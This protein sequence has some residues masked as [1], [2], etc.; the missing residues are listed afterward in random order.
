MRK[1]LT[2]LILLCF[3]AP[4]YGRST[5]ANPDFSFPEDV[6]SVAD[7]VLASRKA[8]D[9]DR[10]NA[11][12]QYAS[13][14]LSRDR[15]SLA[16]VVRR[17]DTE[18]KR[19]TQPDARALMLMYKATLLRFAYNVYD[20]KIYSTVAPLDSLPESFEL[21]SELQ[22]NQQIKLLVDQAIEVMQPVQRS[23]LTRYD[24]ILRW[25][26]LYGERNDNQLKYAPYLR[27][28]I[29]KYAIACVIDG[30]AQDYVAEMCRRADVGT[31]EWVE[32]NSLLT[33]YAPLQLYRQW[34]K[35]DAGAALLLDAEDSLD[36]YRFNNTEQRRL[37]LI[38]YIDDLLAKGGLSPDFVTDL[39]VALRK[40]KCPTVQLNLSGDAFACGTNLQL[41]IKSRF[42]HK[43]GIAVYEKSNPDADIRINT[44]TP[45][46]VKELET[47]YTGETQRDT[48]DIQFDQPGYYT[49][50]LMCNGEFQGLNSRDIS[51]VPYIPIVLRTEDRY[52]AILFDAATG[53]CA[54]D[55]EL[56]YLMGDY[57]SLG[58]TN[59]DGIV[60]WTKEAFYLASGIRL[61]TQDSRGRFIYPRGYCYQSTPASR[62]YQVRFFTPRKV[63][64]RGDTLQWS[65]LAYQPQDRSVEAHRNINVQFRDAN[66]VVFE[67]IAVTTDEYGRATGS[68][69]LPDDRLA[70][71]YYITL[72]GRSYSD[73][74]A[75]EVSDFKIP[76]F[77]IVDLDANRAADGHYVVTGRC[78]TFSGAAVAF[79]RITV[80]EIL[81]YWYRNSRESDIFAT[82][83]TAEDG[84]FSVDLPAEAFKNSQVSL[85]FVANSPANDAA[86]AKLSLNISYPVHINYNSDI[87]LQYYFDF[88]RDEPFQLNG[89]VC[90][91][92]DKPIEQ[93]MVWRMVD[94]DST[95]V[96]NGSFKSNLQGLTTLDFSKIPTGEYE[97]FVATADSTLAKP[98][99][100]TVML[101]SI[102]DN[103]VPRPHGYVAPQTDIQSDA[104][105]H[106]QLVIGTCSEHAAVLMASADN[107]TDFFIC[108]PIRLKA[109]ITRIDVQ[110]PDGAKRAECSV[111]FVDGLDSYVAEYT[112]TRPDEAQFTFDIE[113]WRDN[114]SAGEPCQWRI[115]LRR[116]DGAPA[117]AAMVAT[118]YNRALDLLGGGQPQFL[119][120]YA[121]DYKKDLLRNTTF[122]RSNSI[123]LYITENYPRDNYSYSHNINW[124]NYLYGYDISFEVYQYGVAYGV[125]RRSDV[126]VG[127]PVRSLN[128]CMLREDVASA[129]AV[130]E[131]SAVEQKVTGNSL[132][133]EPEAL[134]EP[135]GDVT[136]RKGDVLQALW[137]PD[138]TTNADGSVTIDFNLPNANGRWAFVL[139]A[140]TTDLHT[141]GLR[142][143]VTTSKPLMVQP[144][145]PRFLRHGDH[146]TLSATVYN[147]SDQRLDATAIIEVYNPANDSIIA[148]S[149][150]VLNLAANGSALTSID[151]VMITDLR[152]I[153]VR[154]KA[155]T[156]HFS[157]GEVN[158]LPV[159]EA[160]STVIESNTFYLNA[161]RPTFEMQLPENLGD[162]TTL[163]YCQNPI[164]EVVKALPR[165][166][167]DELRT[168]TGTAA[169]LFGAVVAQGIAQQHPEV[170]EGIDLWM[171]QGGDAL[172]SA[173]YK[174]EELKVAALK[175]TPWMAFAASQTERM[176]SIALTF[177]PQQAASVYDKA[178]ERLQALQNPDGGF[179]WIDCYERSSRWATVTVLKHLGMANSCHLLPDDNRLNEII[180]NA[181]AYLDRNT[182][183]FEMEYAL[184]YALFPG[185]KPSTLAGQQAIGNA[186]EYILK[187]QQNLTTSSR[188]V[189]ALVL[190]ANGRYASA[191]ELLR[192]LRQF[193]IK[194]PLAGISYPSV[195]DIDSYAHILM[196]FAKIDPDQAE[197]DAMRQW[198]VLRAQVTDDLGS[199]NPTYLIYAILGSG[200]K[201][202][203]LPADAS[204]ITI[205]GETI[206]PDS[207]EQL[208]GNIVYRVP[209]S[210]SGSTLRIDR[211]ADS[212]VSY[213]G[214]TTISTR[215]TAEVEAHALPELSI[216]KRILA[217]RDG[218]WV[219]TTDLIAGEQVRVDLI[220]TSA[221][222]LEYVTI[223]DQRAAN[224]QPL[225]SEQLPRTLW[226][227]GT[228]FYRENNDECTRLFVLYMPRGSYHF[229]YTMTVTTAGSFASGL[230]T[231]QSQLAPA[232]TAH[233]AATNLSAQ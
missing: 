207:F 109:G 195:D 123:A 77:E 31:L 14:A 20:Y 25:Y 150:Q 17:V 97:L 13:A 117:D 67:Q 164:W 231:I 87:S 110:L 50:R 79:A 214:V 173:L 92:A 19:L 60:S 176:Q 146:A 26:S 115:H 229:Q 5:F 219:E 192:S 228:L 106:A 39:N 59:S 23:Q 88:N 172:R 72:F 149:K 18:L 2:L 215:P 89:Y 185:R 53:E 180:D 1:Y 154:V 10:V 82:T 230:T 178:I 156:D 9:L 114:A 127:G 232:I 203:T 27:D 111:A 157:D 81:D 120:P 64:H 66:G 158:L 165:L 197:L 12:T 21:W 37:Q 11:M 142:Q 222:D 96:A 200:S 166:Y 174:N 73:S 187:H 131:E 218:Q 147:T 16:M 161:E 33:G 41:V 119:S 190:A 134:P 128:E 7:S 155:A 194:S 84:S 80:K 188:A 91:V 132:E 163:Q 209:A 56:G 30:T 85:K 212:S 44:Q 191:K 46:L 57:H 8:T 15:D 184:V 104:S 4:I 24:S 186:I 3:V 51:I 189:A 29:F 139:S 148:T 95:V 113:S 63:Y 151:V 201:W 101:Y 220:V 98:Y 71:T 160:S 208:T 170:V 49:L 69:V 6:M 175:Q 105:G 70:G 205:N 28:F 99:K 74:Y 144:S 136:Y 135:V 211:P 126:F 167:S 199:W 179:R 75:F 210:A 116:A 221:R 62:N 206:T 34:P 227:S 45:I 90:N 112:V 133:P 103:S 129:D 58:R 153:G 102:R 43:V 168:S 38:E 202:T 83:T 52:S 226:E 137:L 55:V 177:D 121:F 141:N 22:Y 182:Q 140:W 65:M 78:R 171:A 125:A 143:V 159:L 93:D 48:I 122:I 204:V 36:S 68:I 193:Q 118:L 124:L 162:N 94:A 196:A 145:L 181:L 76:T 224:L 130:E 108:K 61:A 169:A 183:G 217:Q 225:P 216:S 47:T 42:C 213:G 54:P 32:W 233:S 198:L 86:E 223:D 138:L 107:A 100:V 40:L 152:S 35:G